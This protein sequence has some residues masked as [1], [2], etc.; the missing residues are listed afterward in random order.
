M[1]S[2]IELLVRVQQIDQ[3]V[4]E[5]TSTVEESEGRVA[6]LEV[7]LKAQTDNATAL[8]QELEGATVR[9]RDLEGRLAAI[10]AKLR[11][12]RMRITR[13]RNEKELGLAKREVDLLKEE[14]STV[15]T[16]LL[17]VMEEVQSVGAK[18][19]G[20]ESE[21]ASLTQKMA[22]EATELREMIVQLRRELE[23]ERVRR[24]KLVVDLDADLR[25]RYEMIFSRRGGLAVVEVREGTCLGCH[26]HIPPQLA[27]LIQRNEQVILCPNCQ[28]MLFLRPEREEEING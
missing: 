8:R 20:V 9:Q 3:I 25:R 5:K 26:M 16:T 4:R 10:E 18:L 22:S 24:E 1:S 21:I 27:N 17:Q 19:A 7:A 2:Q 23:G 6:A 13:I 14:Q 15:E 28:R 12:R 11:D